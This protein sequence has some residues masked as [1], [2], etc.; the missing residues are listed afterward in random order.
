MNS[1]SPT[2]LTALEECFEEGTVETLVYVPEPAGTD[3]LNA[4]FTVKV[5]HG[6]SG[7]EAVCGDFQSQT[8]NKAVALAK[9]LRKMA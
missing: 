4:E 1:F 5:V 7:K 3:A 2:I 8:Q 9:L 6:P